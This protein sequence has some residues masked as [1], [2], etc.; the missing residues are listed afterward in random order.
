MYR[1]KLKSFDQ[2]NGNYTNN[3]RAANYTV[4]VKCLQTEH[5]LDTK[6]GDDLGFNED[7]TEE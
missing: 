2:Q 5:L 4:H 3:D 7:D 6:P 1:F